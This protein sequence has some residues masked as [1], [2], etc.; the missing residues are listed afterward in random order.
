[1]IGIVN[2]GMAFGIAFLLLFWSRHTRVYRDEL[3]NDDMFFRKRD[4]S[5]GK[6][7][8]PTAR[9]SLDLSV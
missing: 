2:E 6:E 1:M 5:Y 4:C 8:Y 3:V 7:T 9:D